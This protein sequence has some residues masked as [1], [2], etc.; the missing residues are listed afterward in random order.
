MIDSDAVFHTFSSNNHTNTVASTDFSLDF[1][2]GFT[3][4]F[5]LISDGIMNDDVDELDLKGA[6]DR[7]V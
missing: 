3:Q 2:S 5:L 6:P 7:K 1:V 4:I